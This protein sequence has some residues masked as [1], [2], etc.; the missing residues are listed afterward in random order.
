[1]DKE[2]FSMMKLVPD[3]EQRRVFAKVFD[4]QT[5]L[6]V[7]ALAS[8]GYFKV[9][10]FVVSTGKEGHV[11][12]AMD[13]AGNFRAVKIYKI[14]TTDFK[15]M[16]KYVDGDVRFQGIKNNRRD[17]VYAWTRKEFRNL[18]ELN[19]AGVR[20]PLP[21]ASKANVLVMEFIGEKGEAS[22]PLK[23]KYAE[24]AEKLHATLVDFMARM[25]FK[26]RLVHAD[27]SEYNILNKSEEIVVIDCGQA[28]PTTHP[29]AKS[30]F[31][32]DVRNLS[33][34]LNKIGIKSTPESLTEEIRAKKGEFSK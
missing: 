4:R 22:P 17:L 10:E 33:N 14:E 30:F 15:H 16:S 13:A 31:E 9:L 20:V 23:E 11:F 8:K 5:I 25:H 21:I 2:E 34:Y 12:R 26:A 1:M 19:K 27:L 7:H 28:V 24:N 6:A 18:N 29:Y 32:R 3:E